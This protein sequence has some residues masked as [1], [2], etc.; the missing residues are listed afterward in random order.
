LASLNA[1][2]EGKVDLGT[3]AETPIMHAGLREE[4]T[5]LIATIHHADENT[6]IVARKDKGISVPSDLKNKKVG[7]S[8]GT[9]GEF[10]LDS[11]LIMHGISSS[12]IEHVNLKPEEMFYALIN[13]EVDAVSTWNP[14]VIQLQK[15][16]GGNGITIYGEGMY[17][18]TFN[19][20]A[21]QDFVNNNPETIEKVL[22][23]LINAER[24]IKERPD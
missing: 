5:Y 4:K 23:A 1:V 16:L 21:M 15:E 18:E 11:I 12:E 13:G 17:I 19:L 2:I 6:V 8:V 7:V 14:H 10:F 3:V 24:F 9:N 20:V 22:R